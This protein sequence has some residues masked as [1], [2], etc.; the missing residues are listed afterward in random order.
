MPTQ[1]IIRSLRK[2][3]GTFMSMNTVYNSVHRKEAP[4]SFSI[5]ISQTR[6]LS[7]SVGPVKMPSKGNHGAVSYQNVVVMRHG[8][9]FDNLEPSWAATAA[10]PW[11]P[12]LAEPGR[13]RALETAQRLRENLG[14]P[15]Q[16]VFVSPFL[17]CLQTA[18]ELVSSLAAVEEGGS[19]AGDGATVDPLE[20][21]VSLFY[22]SLWLY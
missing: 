1:N 6:T 20:I 8:E 13:K 5:A 3:E 21:K 22:F 15:I 2:L 9:R 18:V 10:R 11:D 17:R 16:R 7:V 4:S 12:P 19:A 14:F